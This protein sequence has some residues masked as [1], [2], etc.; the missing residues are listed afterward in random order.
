MTITTRDST[1]SMQDSMQDR[2][3]FSD[4]TVIQSLCIFAFLGI[5]SYFILRL[6]QNDW[7]QAAVD[8]LLCIAV[9]G[10]FFYV[11]KTGKVELPGAVLAPVLIFGVVVTVYLQG[12]TMVFWAYPAT[13]CAYFLIRPAV[14]LVLAAVS[15]V[16]MIPAIVEMSSLMIVTIII[17]LLTTNL[18]AFF[19]A[20]RTHSQHQLLQELA[21]L[22]PLTNIGNR[23][24]F[25]KTFDLLSSRQGRQPFPM[26]MLL[27]DLDKFKS[28]NDTFG[29]TQGDETLKQ[30]THLI[31]DRLRKTDHLFRFGGEEFLVV[32]EQV[33]LEPARQLAEDLRQL[34][35]SSELG[36]KMGVTIS[37]G[38]AQFVPEES[39]DNWIQRAD[40]ALFSA[41]RAG[42]NRVCVADEEGQASCD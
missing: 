39:C 19:F 18:F 33:E 17:T 12:A 32:A 24:A 5:F 36:Q 7:L 38:V 22:D 29:H 11:R 15:T 16:V 27:M 35:H 10:L 9:M 6:I 14:G 28:V 31:A 37:V 42:R 26:S 1:N 4:D 3:K 2:N 13:V 40:M 25:S 30:F 34:I 21:T 23:R 20:F 41:K 8:A